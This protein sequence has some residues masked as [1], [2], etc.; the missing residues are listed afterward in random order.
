MFKKEMLLLEW[1]I[2][3][4]SLN[5]KGIGNVF[6]KNSFPFC[7]ILIPNSIEGINKL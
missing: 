1:R 3:E 2:F 5:E 4:E 6:D 7:P